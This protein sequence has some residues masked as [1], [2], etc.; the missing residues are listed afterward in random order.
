MGT[1]RLRRKR[2]RNILMDFL[3]TYTADH[4][5]SCHHLDMNSAALC[6]TEGPNAFQSWPQHQDHHHLLTP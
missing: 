2:K 5:I 4:S 3:H 6:L 1:V